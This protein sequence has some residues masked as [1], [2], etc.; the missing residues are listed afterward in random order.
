MSAQGAIRPVEMQV[1]I[2]V[3][4]FS[5]EGLSEVLK[6]HP[7]ILGHELVG[8]EG[9][10]D[11]WSKLI[12]A[13][14]FAGVLLWGGTELLGYGASVMV[15]DEFAEANE[16]HSRPGLNSRVIEEVHAGS[17][18]ILTEKAIARDNAG[19]GLNLAMLAGRWSNS[20]NLTGSRLTEVQNMLGAT[21]ARLHEGYR[22]KRIVADFVD[23]QDR[24]FAE[25]TKVYR[26]TPYLTQ[27]TEFSGRVLGI[28][29]A[30][31]VRAVVG[32]IVYSLFHTPRP[33]LRLRPT[34]QEL[35]LAALEGGTDNEL[36]DRLR[37][38]LAAV[39]RR[40]ESIFRTCEEAGIV[41][42]ETERGSNSKRGSQRRHHV[43]NYMR[44]HMEELR[45][46]DPGVC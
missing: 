4:D 20:R 5:M 12:R 17:K 36:A 13:P 39:K 14:G 46:Y 34:N 32:T 43:L 9:A 45:P 8:R 38:S 21:F 28:A 11:A 29:D 7:A 30:E 37:I 42:A 3:K 44:R 27:T 24:V 26:L 2:E 33:R 41:S 1:D 16:T 19:D 6:I 15:S 10:L 40:W 22:L 35:L 18:H 31:S 25:A 23:E